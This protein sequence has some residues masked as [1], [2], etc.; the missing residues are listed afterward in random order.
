[1]NSKT[2]VEPTQCAEH[3]FDLQ[4]FLLSSKHLDTLKNN[5]NKKII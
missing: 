1:V 3:P 5:P 2:S 4:A